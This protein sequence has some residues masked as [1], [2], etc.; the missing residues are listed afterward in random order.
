MT[1][2]T[3]PEDKSVVNRRPHD[4]PAQLSRSILNFRQLRHFFSLP[5]CHISLITALAAHAKEFQAVS[6]DR[7]IGQP[8][9]PGNLFRAQAGIHLDHLATARAGDVMMVPFPVGTEAEAV[10]AIRE[11][12]AVKQV[13]FL[14]NFDDTED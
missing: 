11:L 12:D 8:P 10:R 4:D 13:Q 5:Q 1:N 6:L 3:I 7:K 14:Q 2:S 9:Y